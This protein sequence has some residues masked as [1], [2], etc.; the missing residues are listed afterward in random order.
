MHTGS[1]RLKTALRFLTKTSHKQ[2]LTPTTK[3][4]EKKQLLQYEQ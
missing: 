3:D 2:K 4:A 1:L